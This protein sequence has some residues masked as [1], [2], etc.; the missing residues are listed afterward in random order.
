MLFRSNCVLKLNGA[1]GKSGLNTNTFWLNYVGDDEY[2]AG[3][4]S[5]K[6]FA[7]IPGAMAMFPTVE[8]ADAT[9][10]YDIADT[11]AITVDGNSI[12]LT[13]AQQV[14]VYD[15]MG[16]MVYQGY[17]D[18]FTIETSG[19]YIV[20]TVGGAVKIEIGRASCRERG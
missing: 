6:S 20:K 8:F 13:E 10:I 4:Y 16:A 15:A 19:I 18:S 9:G 2:E 5:L 11:E 3:F 7:G 17:T 1:Y 12:T 14:S